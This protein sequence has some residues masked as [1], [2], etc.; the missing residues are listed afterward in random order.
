MENF[1]TNFANTNT[2]TNS[3]KGDIK[4]SP[5]FF[6]EFVIS[7]GLLSMTIN[8]YART[9][10]SIYE[11][12][13]SLDDWDVNE[14]K[15]VTFNGLPID[16]I[17]KLINTMK[18]S[19][20][21]TIAEGLHIYDKEIEREIAIQIE[22]SKLFKSIFGKKARMLNALTDKEIEIVKLEYI[23]EKYHNIAL[24]DYVLKNY[25]GYDEDNNVVKPTIEKLQE[26]IN[27]LKK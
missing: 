25:L 2:T 26:Y 17:K 18:D 9:Y 5:E 8:F 27:E 15:S 3:T 16:D 12:F 1:L 21:S 14:K 23:I 22:Q 7:K 11:N 20:L 13:V 4:V 10:K 24:T 6:G 19:G